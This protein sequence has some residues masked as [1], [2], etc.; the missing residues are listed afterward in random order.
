MSLKLTPLPGRILVQE[1]GFVYSGKLTIPESAK[2]RPSIG[3]IIAIGE[4]TEVKA[5]IGDRVLYPM[6]SGTGLRFRDSNTQKD[7][8]PMRVLTPDEILCIVDGDAEL[9]EAGA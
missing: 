7:Q 3:T 9:V 5:K 8:T 1:D 6:Y 2:R 4:G